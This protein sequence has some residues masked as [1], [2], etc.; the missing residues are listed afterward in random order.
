MDRTVNLGSYL[1]DAFSGFAEYRKIHTAEEPELSALWLETENLLNSTFL[2]KADSAGI[3]RFE[4]MMGIV[5]I[6]G[7][8]IESRRLR[9]Q[10]KWMTA[11]P[12]TYKRLQE[13]L[14]GLCGPEGYEVALNGYELIVKVNLAV[15]NQEE[16]AYQ[17]LQNIV[18]AN[19]EL[20]VTLLY[21]TWNMFSA[22][23]W[24]QVKTHTWEA[25]KEGILT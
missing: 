1:P 2:E 18:P 11:R 10:T 24:D 21:N 6:E 3:S 9:L 12:F 7:D 4:T 13:I 20:T 19:I 25:L 5:P 23:T 8:D 17:M 15:R 14:K 22:K 16:I